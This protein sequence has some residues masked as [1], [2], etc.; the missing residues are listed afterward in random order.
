MRIS[1]NSFMGMAPRLAAQKLRAE[2]GQIATNVDLYAG[3]L[4]PMPRPSALGKLAA[5][6]VKALFLYQDRWLT[7]N[8]NADFV[9][10]PI[11]ED[12]LNRV[13]CSF[14]FRAPSLFKNDDM[15]VNEDGDDVVALRTLGVP[16][17]ISAPS[18]S[19]VGGTG[20]VTESRTYVITYVTDLGEEGDISPA[21]TVVDVKI[22]STVSL[23]GISVP[24]ADSFVVKK[25]IY[26]SNTGSS[27]TKFQ[28]VAEID[29][30]AE[31][32]TDSIASSDL[33]ETLS[34][35][36]FVPPPADMRGLIA[37]PGGIM[38]GFTGK[39]VCFSEPYHPYAWPTKY[40]LTTN[41][42]I[43]GL[44]RIGSVLV[45]L[46]SALV[47]LVQCADPATASMDSFDDIAPCVSKRGI[48]SSRWGVIYPSTQGLVS[49]T[50]TGV[51][52]ITRDL[53]TRREWDKLKPETIH[54]YIHAD[55]YIGFH[56]PD[57]GGKGFIVDPV[58]PAARLVDISLNAVAGYVR[59]EDDLCL[60]VPGG[61]GH[62]VLSW[63]QN[64]MTPHVM[65]WRSKDFRTP[66]TLNFST[67]K[68]MCDPPD[69]VTAEEWAVIRDKLIGQ[70]GEE[71]KANPGGCLNDGHL[72][73][74]AMNGSRLDVVAATYSPPAP[75]VFRLYGNGKLRHACE[76]VD[77]YP[78]RLPGGYSAQSWE[79][80]VT[81]S[82][83]VKEIHLVTSVSE[84]S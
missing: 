27:D 71:I 50:L 2:Q 84:L 78:F 36:G 65:Q 11:Y 24:S 70:E 76:V 54:G 52:L 9:Q 14:E 22:D 30:A 46:T 6:S 67:A 49:V 40:Q 64:S 29:A 28:F 31:S 45:V 58:E 83:P 1:I 18:V 5:G 23:S 80:E 43:V 21:S 41:Y 75:V 7:F 69:V 34:T 68:V 47:Y 32:Y 77:G 37:L 19:V 63:A 25:R 61:D 26:R 74:Y 39:T 35:E 57:S 44:G 12:H 53:F 8:E 81:G 4:R 79:V 33:G 60:A 3:E 51:N 73:R 38:A 15:S 59:P 10:G 55:K 20:D 13:Y 16:A 62:K 42:D 48:V 72:G 66:H 17:P 82:R 56:H